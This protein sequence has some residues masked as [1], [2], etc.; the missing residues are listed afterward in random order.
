MSDT[1]ATSK[2]ETQV[3]KLEASNSSGHSPLG[4]STGG[5]AFGAL[6]ASTTT[7]ATNTTHTTQNSGGNLQTIMDLENKVRKLQVDFATLGADPDNTIVYFALL[8][9]SIIQMPWLSS[10]QTLQLFILPCSYSF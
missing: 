8:G 7:P 4:G 9:F 3:S 2:L 1:T 5:F 10:S 6:G